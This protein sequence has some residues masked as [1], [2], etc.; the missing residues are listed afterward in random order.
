MTHPILDHEHLIKYDLKR[1]LWYCPTCGYEH[2]SY[3]APRKLAAGG[4]T[5]DQLDEGCNRFHEGR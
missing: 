4:F 2:P 1:K 3:T 5:P